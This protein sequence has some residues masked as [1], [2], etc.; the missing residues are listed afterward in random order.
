VTYSRPAFASFVVVGRSF[1]CLGARPGGTRPPARPV[2]ARFLRAA[3][4][5]TDRQN[6]GF[7]YYIH[8]TYR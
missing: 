7:V 5:Q 3:L 4:R 1:V 2:V 6:N 8:D